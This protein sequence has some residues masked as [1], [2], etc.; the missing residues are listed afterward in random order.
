[1]PSKNKAIGEAKSAC[2]PACLVK[3]KE[4]VYLSAASAETPGMLCLGVHSEESIERRR[5]EAMWPATPTNCFI[6]ALEA[7]RTVKHDGAE[8]T[9]VNSEL[10]ST[11]AQGLL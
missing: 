5:I 10:S 2:K 3:N 6:Y 1:M 4:V 8:H 7:P 9:Q 11:N